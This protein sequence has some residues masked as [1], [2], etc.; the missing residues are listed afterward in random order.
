MYNPAALAYYSE[1]L[2]LF[3]ILFSALCLFNSTSVFKLFSH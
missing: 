2:V 3:M 1:S